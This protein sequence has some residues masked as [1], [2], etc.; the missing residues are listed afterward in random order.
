MPINCFEAITFV[1]ELSQGRTTPSILRCSMG[2]I[3][4]DFVI[5]YRSTVNNGNIGLSFELLASQ[6][7]VYF[8]IATP[9]PVFIQISDLFASCVSNTATSEK[10]RKSIGLNFGSKFIKGGTYTL[11]QTFMTPVLLQQACLCPVF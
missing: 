10:L 8:G 5:K 7:A 11:P 3:H 6:L 1:E 9:D 2:E 4:D